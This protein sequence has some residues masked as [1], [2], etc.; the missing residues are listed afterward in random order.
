M[1]ILKNFK[2]KLRYKNYSENTIS[3]YSHYLEKFLLYNNVKDPYQVTTKQIVNFLESYRFSSISQQNQYIGSL[4]VFARF[5]LSKKDIHLTKI[6]RPKKEK[7]LPKVVDKK[8]LL[9][10]IKNIKNLKH[11]TIMSL[12]YSTG[13]RVSEVCNLKI[14]DVD[15]KRMIINIVQAKGRKDRV[16]PLS[17]NILEL[18]RNYVKEYRPKIH[19]F[20]GQNS[21]KYSH[22]SCNKIVKKYLGSQYHFHQLRH[23]CFTSLLESGTDLRVIQKIAGHSSS[24]TTEV[25]THVSTQLLSKVQL[26][27]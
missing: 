26:P 15:S 9:D 1:K 21:S 22:T 17:Q 3:I 25:Y 5:I 14:E 27:I 10:K 6:E 4:K 2:Q 23:S 13:M 12:A 18:L 24:K 20:N 7:S 8:F 19:L 11:K 16:V